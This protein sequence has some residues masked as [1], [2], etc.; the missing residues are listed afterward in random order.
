MEQQTLYYLYGVAPADAAE[1]DPPLHGV[2]G[3]PV[4]LLRAGGL[5]GIVSELPPALYA[6]GELDARMADLAWVGERGLAH[7]R[8]LTAFSDAGPVVPLS[9]FS[10]HAGEARVRERLEQRRRDFAAALERL[11]GR[12]EF[13]IRLWRG[14]AA[15]E[16][17]AEASE[18]MRALEAELSAAAP[19]RRFLLEKKRAALRDES[20]R[21]G[22][23]AL[24]RATAQALAAVS[25][26]VAT[27]PLRPPPADAPRTLV[28]DLACLVDDARYPELQREVTRRAEEAGRHGFEL[29][30]TG[31]W[32]AYHF[33]AE[34][35]DG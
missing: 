29:E 5:A 22:T 34:R 28:L 16:R 12:R 4:A 33:A 8:V 30:F 20:M 19:G 9:P 14:P 23:A 25:A 27:L 21:T 1:P 2:E 10:L 6:E 17:L 7:E 3:A 18:A 13:L 11:R 31:P 32:P 15:A 24:S 26:D 35:S